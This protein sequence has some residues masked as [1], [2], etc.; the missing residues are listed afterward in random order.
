MTQP[1][2]LNKEQAIDYAHCRANFRSGEIRV[3]DSSGGTERIIPFNEANRK[4]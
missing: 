4:L 3:F 1:V 2:F